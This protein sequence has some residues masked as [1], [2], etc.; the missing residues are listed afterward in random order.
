[1]EQLTL[2]GL[3]IP[4]PIKL[5]IHY[6]TN[7]QLPTTTTTQNWNHQAILGL[8]SSATFSRWLWQVLGW[9][10]NC[11]KSAGWSSWFHSSCSWEVVGRLTN[12]LTTTSRHWNSQDFPAANNSSSSSQPKLGIIALLNGKYFTKKMF[13]FKTKRLLPCS[14][15]VDQLISL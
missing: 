10:A 15:T 4:Q 9:V 2:V 1:M 6:I 8:I 3:Q 11:H 12:L 5:V 13:R 14:A 7:Y